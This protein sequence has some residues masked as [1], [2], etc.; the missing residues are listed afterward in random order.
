ML[1]PV[2]QLYAHHPPAATRTG[3]SKWQANMQSL[4]NPTKCCSRLL[5]LTT[6]LCQW[7]LLRTAEKHV[8]PALLSFSAL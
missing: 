5:L 6:T 4:N 8:C 7:I 1:L 2:A 3:H